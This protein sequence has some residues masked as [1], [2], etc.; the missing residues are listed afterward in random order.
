VWQREC[1]TKAKPNRV[2]TSNQIKS[3][4]MASYWTEEWRKKTAGVIIIQQE[5]N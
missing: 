4:Q 2:L 1:K 3:N 5:W